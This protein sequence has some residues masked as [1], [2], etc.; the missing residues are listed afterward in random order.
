M[1]EVLPDEKEKKRPRKAD[2]EFQNR[3]KILID[4]AGS[5]EKLAKK[6]GVG[7]RNI[8][9][10]ASGDGEPARI[11]LNKLARATGVN[12]LWLSMG[13]GPMRGEDAVYAMGDDVK[14]AGY[15]Q[16][17]RYEVSAS[18]GGGA[19]IHSEQIVDHLSFKA[20]WVHNALG[21]KV[22]SLALINVT[23]DSMEP[24]LSEGDLILIDMSFRGVKDN[25][26]YV[27]QLNGS[28]LVKRIQHKLDGSVVVKSDNNI[29][30]P[31]LVGREAVSALNIIGRV[32]W[33]GRR[34]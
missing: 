10:Y 18:A 3:I 25:A 1:S 20:D 27:L 32:V 7:A 34:M 17:P 13:E 22:S 6:S 4:E 29:Y 28:L 8:S 9:K 11:R 24:T 23:G 33:S 31:E 14:S 5:A 21:V 30:E 2:E 15:V 16:V 19:M 12:L 26:V